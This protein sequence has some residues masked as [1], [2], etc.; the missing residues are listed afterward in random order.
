MLDEPQDS[1]PQ[2][3]RHMKRNSATKSLC[4]L[5]RIVGD[6]EEVDSAPSASASSSQVTTPIKQYFYTSAADLTASL[7]SVPSLASLLNR[8]NTTFPFPRVVSEPTKSHVDGAKSG[9]TPRIA[10][11]NSQ[12][13]LKPRAVK[14]AEEEQCAACRFF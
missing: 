14:G 12:L 4:N 13:Q 11:R 9:K 3:R 10:A 6:E 1:P 7:P 5:Q 8:P 2:P